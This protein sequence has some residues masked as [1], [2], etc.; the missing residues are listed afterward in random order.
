MTRIS[1]PSIMPAAQPQTPEIQITNPSFKHPI[2]VSKEKP[3]SAFL[4]NIT[5]QI[6]VVDYYSQ[7]LGRD[8]EVSSPELGQ[9]AIYQQ[10]R[11][12][13]NLEI[14][15]D[16]ALSSST[17]TQDQ[18]MTVSGRGYLYP[19]LKPNKGDLFLM[20]LGNGMGGRFT[21]E[22]VEQKYLQK[23]TIYEITFTLAKLINEEDFNNIQRKVIE[24]LHFVK[25]FMLYGQNPII[26]DSDFIKLNTAKQ[27]FK[28]VLSSFI[29]EFYSTRFGT[30][31][32]PTN[33][34]GGIYDTFATK[35]FLQVMD[36]S[37][38]RRVAAVQEFNSSEI[39]QYY[40]T[41]I[42]TI[43][44]RPALAK[45]K[46]IWT[47]AGEMRVQLLNVEPTYRSLR[48]SGFSFFVKPINPMTNVD[49]Y[50]GWN[51]RSLQGYSSLGT[52]GGGYYG[53][54]GN[55]LNADGE[56]FQQCYRKNYYTINHIYMWKHNPRNELSYIEDWQCRKPCDESESTENICNDFEDGYI[57][58]GDFWE[59]EFVRD[60]WL[61]VVR[62]HLKD[63]MVD[64]IRIIDLLSQRKQ[65][66]RKER[67]YKTLILLIIL[68][69]AIRRL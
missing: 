39:D 65:W 63:T 29:D 67:F 26:V 12:I 8:S 35:A 9:E 23:E 68:K 51:D 34:M 27:T 42:W 45:E 58:K 59:D 52:G 19:Y 44:I 7:V 43:L 66:T 11:L 69:S 49:D 18:E 57:F 6:Q 50:N 14:K 2:V 3:L 60:E 46:N 53:S 10:Y 62:T 36:I 15:F 47:R 1:I 40:E 56:R 64:P 13:K 37:D 28:G 4:V 41:S 24:T 31:V 17:D 55:A 54:D 22:E 33:G 38:D 16:G 25:D 21:V 61:S 48:Y 5:G 30:I 32:V 20:D